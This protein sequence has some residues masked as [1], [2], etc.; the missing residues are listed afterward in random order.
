MASC[1]IS[2]LA[3]SQ[4]YQ[5]R[6]GLCK[7]QS[8]LYYQDQ[9]QLASSLQIQCKSIEVELARA[10]DVAGEPRRSGGRLAT[11]LVATIFIII[12]FSFFPLRRHLFS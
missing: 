2:I 3:M 12:F 1:D 11:T 7:K 5:V 10:I 4:P 6:F 8:L 9:F